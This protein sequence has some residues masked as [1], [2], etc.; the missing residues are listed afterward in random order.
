MPKFKAGVTELIEKNCTWKSNEGQAVCRYNLRDEK[1]NLIYCFS[2]YAN[3][4]EQYGTATAAR[5]AMKSAIVKRILN[6]RSLANEYQD[7][8]VSNPNVTST[9]AALDRAAAWVEKNW[10]K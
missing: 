9:A 6:L 8:V 7:M 3:V 10:I 4:K 1:G 5:S 2:I